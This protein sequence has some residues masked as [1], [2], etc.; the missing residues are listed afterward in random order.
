[1]MISLIFLCGTTFLTIVK[2]EIEDYVKVYAKLVAKGLSEP[3]CIAVMQEWGRD[4]RTELIHRWRG[5]KQMPVVSG[6]SYEQKS[7]KPATPKQ[8]AY[9]DNLV[10]WGKLDGYPVNLTMVQ[11]DQIF[12]QLIE[13]GI[14]TDKKRKEK[15]WERNS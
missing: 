11:A 4:Q 7:V 10:K 12:K 15:F 9:L 1:M 2:M 3:V 5:S 6:Q 14:I 13:K 8:I